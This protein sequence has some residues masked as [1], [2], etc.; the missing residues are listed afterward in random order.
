MFFILILLSDLCQLTSEVDM[1][2]VCN[3]K[4]NQPFHNK[5]HI[6]ELYSELQEYC[7][8]CL[9]Y[10]LME[11]G[12]VKCMNFTDSQNSVPYIVSGDKMIHNKI[13]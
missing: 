5:V 2:L 3:P 1:L 10:F 7:P 9:K 8:N 6:S 11:N 12:I 13:T 4:T